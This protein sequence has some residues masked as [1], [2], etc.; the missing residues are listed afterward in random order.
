MQDAGNSLPWHRIKNQAMKS[1]IY[2]IQ[3]LQGIPLT[4]FRLFFL[5]FCLF[6]SGCAVLPGAHKSE[7]LSKIFEPGTIISA[8]TGMPITF[9]ALVADLSRARVVYVGEAHTNPAHHEIQLKVIKALYADNPGLVVGMEMFDHT[10]QSVLDRWSAGELEQEAFL[11][12]VQWSVNWGYN[13]ELY[14]EILAFIK[15]KHIRLVA[16]NLPNYIPPRV[17]VGGIANLTEADKQHLPEEID[18]TNTEH[19]AYIQKIFGRHHAMIKANFEYF[20]QAQCV[21]EDT[22]AAAVARNLKDARMVVLTGNGHIIRKFGVPDRAYARCP[23]PFKTVYTAAE[24]SRT[25]RDYGDYIW[26]TTQ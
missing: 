13:F 1:I 21:W 4:A 18:L 24:G 17:R 3:T 20:Y 25:E 10:Y 22:M 7:D 23:A 11:E 14:Q 16:L 12:K 6:F 2:S 26:I 19:R 8:D 5:G 9:E 15:A